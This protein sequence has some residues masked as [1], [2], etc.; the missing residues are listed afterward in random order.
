MKTRMND[1]RRRLERLNKKLPVP[2]E[3][4]DDWLTEDQKKRLSIVAKM[5]AARKSLQS[6]ERDTEGQD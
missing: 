3:T 5:I 2:E 4:L 1:L 6:T